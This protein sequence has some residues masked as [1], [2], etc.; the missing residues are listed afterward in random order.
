MQVKLALRHQPHELKR[1]CTLFEVYVSELCFYLNLAKHRNT[2]C[3][4]EKVLICLYLAR[5][6]L[7][8][9]LKCR[10]FKLDDDIVLGEDIVLKTQISLKAKQLAK[11]GGFVWRE[12][13][14]GVGVRVYNA[15]KACFGSEK[16]L[17]K[18]LVRER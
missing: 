12:L 3:Y 11:L 4:G 15:R 5:K 14:E 2:C 10:A 16:A 8:Q 6:N 18:V 9:K 13:I 7:A 1:V 17:L